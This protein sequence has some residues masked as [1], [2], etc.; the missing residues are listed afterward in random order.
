[1]LG[2]QLFYLREALDDLKLAQQ[3]QQ[4]FDMEAKTAEGNA[5]SVDV[6][7]GD[8][9]YARQLQLQFST[10]VKLEGKWR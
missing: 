1:M 4:Q 3:L 9:A 5:E 7:T 6:F 2:V 8:E 10:E